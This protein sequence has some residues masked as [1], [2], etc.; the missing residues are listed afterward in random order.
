LAA[1]ALAGG[2]AGAAGLPVAD[3]ASATDDAESKI[4]IVRDT[5]RPEGFVIGGTP[6]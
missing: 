1:G 6:T 5:T 2:A 3:C 4:A